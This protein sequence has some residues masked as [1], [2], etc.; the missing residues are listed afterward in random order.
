MPNLYT[1]YHDQYIERFLVTSDIKNVNKES[2]IVL[3][4]IHTLEENVNL[5]A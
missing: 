2:F 1:K 4:I 3:R 5:A